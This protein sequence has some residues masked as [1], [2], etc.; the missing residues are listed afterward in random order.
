MTGQKDVDWKAKL[1]DMIKGAQ[2]ELKRATKLGKKL[3]TASHTNSELH[4]TFEELGKLT[5]DSIKLGHL[6]WEHVQAKK[7][8]KKIDQLEKEMELLEDEVQKIKGRR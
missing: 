4:Q 6:D 8:L 7:L 2:I 1:Q 3:V 5:R